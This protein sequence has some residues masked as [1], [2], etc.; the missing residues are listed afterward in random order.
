MRGRSPGAGR[1]FRVRDG[2][3]LGMVRRSSPCVAGAPAP[4]PALR[5][6]LRS[7]MRAP[8]DIRSVAS[9]ENPAQ[10]SARPTSGPALKM[11]RHFFVRKVGA[12]I[13]SAASCSDPRRREHPAHESIAQC[14]ASVHGSMLIKR[15]LT[16]AVNHTFRFLGNKSDP[17]I[18]KS[19]PA[20][21]A[22][23]PIFEWQSLSTSAPSSSHSP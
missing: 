16:F 19:R 7:M 15:L 10:R 13:L 22:S 23:D 5:N 6:A 11:I 12:R 4:A 9:H 14:H 18:S 21:L 3:D 2:C 20:K 8:Q 1:Q 17:P